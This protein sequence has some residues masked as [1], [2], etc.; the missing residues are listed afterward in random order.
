M[1]QLVLIY[2]VFWFVEL[3]K[4]HILN[5]PLLEHSGG[6]MAIDSFSSSD[7]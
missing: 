2:T 1:E 3:T 6:F 4:I 7:H 5:Y